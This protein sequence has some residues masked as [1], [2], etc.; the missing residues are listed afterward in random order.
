MLGLTV[1]AANYLIE[2]DKTMKFNTW[3]AVML[4]LLV[5]TYIALAWRSLCVAKF[6]TLGSQFSHLGCA[7]GYLN[8][9]ISLIYLR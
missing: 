9:P 4:N 2:W 8:L 7:C 6:W 3:S 1:P 5:L